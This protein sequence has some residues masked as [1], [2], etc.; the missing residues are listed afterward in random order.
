MAVIR[1]VR[2]CAGK[3]A[4]AQQEAALPADT[5]PPP[6]HTPPAHL[7]DLCAAA[8]DVVGFAHGAHQNSG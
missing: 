8:L 5:L 1:F 4:S 7:S 2:G 6:R 3:A